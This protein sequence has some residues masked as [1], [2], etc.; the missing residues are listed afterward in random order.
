[1]TVWVKKGQ[2]SQL[3][4]FTFFSFFFLFIFFIF[5]FVTFSR[6]YLSVPPLS[7]G[8]SKFWVAGGRQGRSYYTC[9]VRTY[10]PPGLGMKS[11]VDK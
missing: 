4:K 8:R 10:F 1:M 6:C 3:S 5:F 9:L 7:L 2:Y 11:V